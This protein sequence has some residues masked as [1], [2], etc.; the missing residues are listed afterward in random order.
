MFAR[1]LGRF[2]GGLVFVLVV[3]F[4]GVGA[5]SADTGGYDTDASPSTNSGYSTT[6]IVEWE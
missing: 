2:A 5:A 1:K 4:G 6:G 3:V